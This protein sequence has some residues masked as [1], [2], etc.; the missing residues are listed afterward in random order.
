MD[1]RWREL[2][3]FLRARRDELQPSDI[4]LPEP[5]RKRRVPGLRREEVAAAASISTDY[6]ARLE[7]GRLPASA[8][9][10]DD[11]ARVL[12]L[13]VDQRAYLAGLAGKVIPA[14]TPPLRSALEAPVRRMLDDLRS[15]PAFVMGPRTEILGWNALGA[16]L[17][18]DFSAIPVAERYFIR[19]LFRDPAMRELYADWLGVVD[20]AI[21][22]LRMD[23][24]RDPDDPLL[25]ALVD[26]LTATDSDFADL[27]ITHEVAARGSGWK[28]LHHPVVGELDLQWEALTAGAGGGHTVIIWTA[29]PGSQS[30]DRLQQLASMTSG[31]AAAGR[32]GSRPDDPAGP[33]L[34]GHLD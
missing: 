3:D 34:Q 26:E 20:L 18:T 12:R 25:H 31:T 14:T 9:V 16:A 11:L 23:S 29:E 30:Y 13:S 4:G 28:T 6:Y 27:W 17:I 2:G 33:Q 24:L 7:Q 21:A 8:P 32:T 1:G 10:L 22:Q 5:A 19:L 15:T